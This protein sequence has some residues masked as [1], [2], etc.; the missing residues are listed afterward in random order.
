MYPNLFGINDFSYVFMIIVGVIAALTLLF[1]FLYKK[2][3]PSN[4]FLDLAIVSLATIFMGVV[5][6]ILFENVYEAIKHAISGEAQSW[7]WAMTFYGGLIGGVPT[8]IL[9]YKFYYLR[10]NKPIL[11]KV[12]I[13]APACITLA[14]AFGR[15]GC[16]LAGCC[17]G[18]EAVN[19]NGMMFPG[20]DH[21]LVPTQLIESI[22][23]FTLSIGLIILSFKYNF[24]YTFVIYA[25]F[26]G[27]FRFIIEFF[28]GDERGQVGPLSPSQ[29]ICLIA[30][31]FAIPLYIFLKKKMPKQV[32]EQ[33]DEI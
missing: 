15:I 3:V 4:S 9:I 20:H 13:I 16:L 5:F 28:R 23:L 29:I 32:E 12:V 31:I 2:G 27:I 25:I 7:T 17:Y 30:I 21:P 33:A 24:S 8:F 6:A 19:G 11:S 1:I 26:Y 14:H 22:F 10:H 18:I